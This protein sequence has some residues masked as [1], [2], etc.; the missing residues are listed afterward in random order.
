MIFIEIDLR[1]INKRIWDRIKLKEFLAHLNSLV[2][3]DAT[4]E[5]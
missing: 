3:K 2:Q 4:H 1:N 5:I